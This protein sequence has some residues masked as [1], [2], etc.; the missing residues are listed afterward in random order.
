M[1]QADGNILGNELTKWGLHFLMNICKDTRKVVV[2]LH[3]Q[4]QSKFLCLCMN[5][6]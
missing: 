6:E 1:S 3:L 2:K 4:P 5:T